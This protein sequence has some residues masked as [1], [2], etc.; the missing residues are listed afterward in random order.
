MAPVDSAPTMTEG[1]DLIA[2]FTAAAAARHAAEVEVVRTLGRLARAGVIEDLEALP[3]DVYLAVH[4]HFTSAERNMLLDAADMLV[5]M[6]ATTVLW[7]RG[8]LSG[9]QVRGM[10]T[11]LRRYGRG[12][13]E[14]LD[15]MIAASE[16]VIGLADPDRFTSMVDEAILDLRSPESVADEE[17]RTAEQAYLAGR[18]GDADTVELHGEYDPPTGAMVLNAIDARAAIDTQRMGDRRPDGRTMTRAQR[19][20]RALAGICSDSLDGGGVE[21]RNGRER[22]RPLMVVHVQA[23]QVTES[24]AGH[25]EV[26]VPSFLPTVAAR[27]LEALAADA[28]VRDVAAFGRPP[29]A[30]DHSWS[31]GS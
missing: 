20:A 28:E 15:G 13:R 2:A 11:R 3:I 30:T 16:E 7:A 1:V 29:T 27:T 6:P 22:A 4:Q 21:N 25:L 10:L 12:L 5:D 17:D 14:E 19:R 26:P 9:S 23:D 31:P 8:V 24:V 18:A